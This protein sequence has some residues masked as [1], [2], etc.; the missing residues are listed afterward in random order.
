MD[1]IGMQILQDDYD[2]LK[3]QI[4]WVKVSD[5]LPDI[6]CKVLFVRDG[7]VDCGYFNY[8]WDIANVTW[9]MPLPNPPQE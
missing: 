7:E 2:D 5:R 1:E 4:E 9:W 8:H 6:D 3:K